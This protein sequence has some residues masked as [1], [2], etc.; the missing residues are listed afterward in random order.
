MST[1]TL[2]GIFLAATVGVVIFLFVSLS[3]HDAKAPLVV[4]TPTA[5][6][7]TAAEVGACLPKVDYVDTI[8][9][10]YT[11]AALAGKVVVVNFWATW[12][13]P[14]KHELPDFS[15]VATAYADRGVV[16]LGV[17]T[18]TPD[19]QTLL[20]F[21]SDFEIAYPIVRATPAIATAFDYPRAITG[22]PTTYVYDRQGNRRKI[23]V[24]PMNEHELRAVLDT[25]LAEPVAAS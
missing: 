7:C 4:G 5:T 13:A 22:I 24:G 15:K 6:A 18:D 3:G 8:G 9:T 1:R 20:N 17:L 14:C 21:M 19:P 2:I 25:L 10:A 16:I 11:P 23:E 12:C